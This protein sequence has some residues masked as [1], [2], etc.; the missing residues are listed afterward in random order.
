MVAIEAIGDMLEHYVAKD[1]YVGT[2][3]GAYTIYNYRQLAIAEMYSWATYTLGADIYLPYSYGEG[4]HDGE[5]FYSAV[6]AGGHSIYSSVENG[7][8][9]GLEEVLR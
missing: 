2:M 9:M 1:Y 6:V 5:Y 4:D 7:S 8:F 3:A